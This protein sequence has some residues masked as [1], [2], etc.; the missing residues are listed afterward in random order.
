MGRA[1]IA[2]WFLT[3]AFLLIVS[4]L[5]NLEIIQGRSLRGLG[6]KNCIRLISQRGSRG[7][8]LDCNGLVI[9][10]NKV[11]YDLM[12]T[13]QD[14][15]QQ[16]ELASKLSRILGKDSKELEA[17]IRRSYSFS[18]MPVVIAGNLKLREAVA[19]GQLRIDY[20][21][22]TV[23]ANPIRDY[24]NNKLA[25]HL[26]GYLGEI[27]RWRLTKLKDYGYKTKDLVGFGG[28][29]EKYDYYLRDEEGGISFQ[30]DH[31]GRLVRTL[32]F[33]PRLTE[34]I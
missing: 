21:Y 19:L 33:K 25:S 31:R 5:F 1:K 6:D 28:I 12:L 11:S 34:R 7:R 30:V 8:I 13:P 16:D 22:I 32:G 4:G 17:V 10:G 20:P 27:D 24:P 29:E 14:Y 26:L 3:A 18:S 2:I 23:Q 9:A 15:R